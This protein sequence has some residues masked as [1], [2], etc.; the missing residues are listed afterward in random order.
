MESVRL[1]FLQNQQ[2][3]QPTFTTKNNIKLKYYSFVFLLNR[4]SMSGPKAEEY[5][6]RFQQDGNLA[7]F[8]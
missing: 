2:F 6:G 5:M 7:S 1:T 4:I 8:L 3:K